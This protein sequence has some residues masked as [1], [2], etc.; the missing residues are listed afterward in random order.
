VL[1]GYMW[2]TTSGIIISDQPIMCT[3]VS[4]DDLTCALHIIACFLGH[5]SV[6][7]L[8][9]NTLGHQLLNDIP[10]FAVSQ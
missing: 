9:V 1:L 6:M 2:S 10:N 8:I 3:T 4:T 5:L 7:Q